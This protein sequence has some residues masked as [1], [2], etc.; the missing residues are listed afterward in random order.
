MEI[1]IISNALIPAV[2]NHRCWKSQVGSL[3]GC[4]VF[5]DYLEQSQERFREPLKDVVDFD[6]K[7]IRLEERTPA[8]ED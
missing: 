2:A 3:E 7:F 6:V 1:F 4:K 5:C 8:F